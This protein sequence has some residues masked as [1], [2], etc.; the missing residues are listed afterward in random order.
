MSFLNGAPSLE[1]FMAELASNSSVYRPFHFIGLDRCAETTELL[2][3]SLLMPLRSNVSNG[4]SLMSITN[5]SKDAGSCRKWPSNGMSINKIRAL[6]DNSV[7]KVYSASGTA[8]PILP[9]RKLYM[10]RQSLVK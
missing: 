5:K 1:H 9:S 10:A 2:H 4:Y 3:Y 6:I 8:R 7:F